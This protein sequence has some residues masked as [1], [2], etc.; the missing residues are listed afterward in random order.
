[1]THACRCAEAVGANLPIRGKDQLNIYQRFF[2][3][4]TFHSADLRF[5]LFSLPYSKVFSTEVSAANMAL[6]TM[7]RATGLLQRP[8]AGV[9]SPRPTLPPRM[10]TIMRF[11]E[12]N[13]VRTCTGAVRIVSAQRCQPDICSSSNSSLTDILVVIPHRAPFSCYI[14]GPD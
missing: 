10:K 4:N 9:F 1:M 2:L 6:S 5:V 8:A 13:D 3:Y 7:T 14:A 12:E 11:R